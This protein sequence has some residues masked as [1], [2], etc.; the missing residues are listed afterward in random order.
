MIKYVSLEITAGSEKQF[1]QN[2]LPQIAFVGKSN[3]GK[4]SLINSMVYR[5][6]L[7][8]TS[9]SP[10][11]TR[12][13]NFYN[14]DRK[15][16]FVD[17]PGY[18]YARAS[19]DA[20]K[21]WNKLIEDYLL[22]NDSLKAVLLLVDI[23]HDPGKNDKLMYD[24]LK[25]YKL[26]TIIV[27]TKSDKIKSG[28]VDKNISVIRERLDPEFDIDMMIPFSNKSNFTRERLWGKINCII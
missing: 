4:S 20:I 11:K 27:A 1:P 13:I 28:A 15:L 6:S 18:G 9:N 14:V 25:Y 5:K 12:T 23:R 2:N 22:K 10:G 3:V 17:L 19:K 24:W 21:R 7:A 16:Y 8:H 26:K